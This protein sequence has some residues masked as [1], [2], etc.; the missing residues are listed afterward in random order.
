MRKNARMR[1]VADNIRKYRVNLDWSQE[2]LGEIAGVSHAFINQLENCKR[3]MTL[4]YC[5]RICNAL[6]ITP[7]DLLIEQQDNKYENYN[8]RF[9][10][11]INGL[12]KSQIIF[13]LDSLEVLRQP[14]KKW[15]NE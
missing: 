1:R 11:I 4:E 13:L 3:D 8:Q 10:H 2:K 6:Q 7:N 5:I 15:V 14:V 12:E 9:L